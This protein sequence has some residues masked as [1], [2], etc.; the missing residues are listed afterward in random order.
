MIFRNFFQST[1]WN[2]DKLDVIDVTWEMQRGSAR[3]CSEGTDGARSSSLATNS[4]GDDFANALL[5]AKDGRHVRTHARTRSKGIRKRGKSVASARVWGREAIIGP[6]GE[7]K[8]KERR[9][10]LSM[11]ESVSCVS[12]YRRTQLPIT[13]NGLQSDKSAIK[14]VGRKHSR[15]VRLVR[16]MFQLA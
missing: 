8:Q 7:R 10:A 9:V 2:S 3:G 14:F 5:T 1:R 6:V 16:E 15:R 4:R 11:R 12:F 13:R